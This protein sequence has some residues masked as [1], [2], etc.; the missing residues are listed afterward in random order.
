MSRA[1]SQCQGAV[2][3]RAAVL[4]DDESRDYFGASLADEGVQ[5]VW[6]SVDNASDERLHFLPVVTDPNYFSATEVS[7]L[8]RSWWRGQANA[9]ISAALVRQAMP[10][11]IPPGK[12]V[13]GFVWR[14]RVAV[15]IRCQWAASHMPCRRSISAIFIRQT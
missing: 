12:P 1:E 8:V 3:V 14:P 7:R 15:Q 10:E 6:L 13:S 4:T 2:T 11:A 5:A 9:S